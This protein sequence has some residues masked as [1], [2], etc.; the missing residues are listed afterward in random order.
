[1]KLKKQTLLILLTLGFLG[2]VNYNDRVIEKTEIVSNQKTVKKRLQK[3]II[4]LNDRPIS[5]YSNALFYRPY[6]PEATP[7]NLPLFPILEA[8]DINYKWNQIN[9][10]L[11]IYDGKNTVKIDLNSGFVNRNGYKIGS[12]EFTVINGE[13]WIGIS[14]SL[15]LLLGIDRISWNQNTKE[16]QLYRFPKQNDRQTFLEKKAI[17]LVKDYLTRGNPA[18]RTEIDD[19]ER[20]KILNTNPETIDSSKKQNLAVRNIKIN[21]AIQLSPADNLDRG[22]VKVAVS[23]TTDYIPWWTYNVPGETNH[24]KTIIVK[25][26]RREMFVDEVIAHKTNRSSTGSPIPLLKEEDRI[27]IYRE[28][29]RKLSNYYS[30]NLRSLSRDFI[31]PTLTRIN[32][33]NDF[34]LPKLSDK[35]ILARFSEEVRQSRGWQDFV[36]LK[37]AKDPYFYILEA[38]ETNNSLSATLIGN[39]SCNSIS[40]TPILMEIKLV[41]DENDSWKFTSI[42]KVRLYKNSRQL[43]LNEPETYQELARLISYLRDVNLGF[44]FNL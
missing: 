2:F 35:A 27:K 13:V 33:N 5:G 15:P 1:M 37:G 10:N 38:T 8:M 44:G 26:D 6:R 23:Y 14:K 20:A 4:T 7:T 21:S 42:T 22:T 24:E 41:K 40:L 9:N 17:D 29:H 25:A 34:Y 18:L 31:T 36:S 43:E 3:Y 12:P 16:W 30:Q 28:S 19:R 32:T 11:A 39:W